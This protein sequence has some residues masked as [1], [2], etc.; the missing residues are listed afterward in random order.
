[1]ILS[2]ILRVLPRRLNGGMILIAVILILAKNTFSCE[3]E[4]EEAERWS[5]L[6]AVDQCGH[7]TGM[8]LII[9]NSGPSSAQTYMQ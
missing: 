2:P 3:V 7:N 4:V 1:M 8:C 9:T 6:T 5:D